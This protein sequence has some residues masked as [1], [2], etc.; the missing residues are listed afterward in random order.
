[1][2]I[3]LLLILAL[4]ALGT[5]ALADDHAQ[6]GPFYAFYHIQ[7]TNPAAVVAAMDK[8]WDSDCGKQYPADADQQHEPTYLC[9]SKYKQERR[10]VCYQNW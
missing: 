9:A 3:R 4:G 1:M 10:I 2:K 6:A 8:F 5:Q 7:S